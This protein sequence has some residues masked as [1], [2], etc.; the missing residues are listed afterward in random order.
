[1]RIAV[2]ADTHVALTRTEEITWHNPLR[3]ADAHVRLAAALR[4]EFVTTSNVV[5]VLG[6]LSHFGDRTSIEHVVRAFATCGR[7]VLMIGGNHDI[8]EPGV[9]LTPILQEV[10]ADS[11][12][13]TYSN[14]NGPAAK[15]FAEAGLGLQC[16]EVTGYNAEGR[17]RPMRTSCM[18]LVPPQPGG[19]TVTLAHFPV[20]S[21]RDRC[22]AAGLRYSQHRDELA[23]I[24]DAPPP[25]DP[26][27][28]LHGHLHLRGWQPAGA[29]LQLGFAALVETP[30]EVAAV[31]IE[32]GSSVR[33]DVQCEAVV[34]SDEPVPALDPPHGSWLLDGRRWRDGDGTP[35]D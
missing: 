18:E 8:W 35:E 27:L 10:A 3:L 11:V 30:F 21:L 33:V 1:V 32:L 13:G 23:D 34:D 15:A 7:P 19:L 16:W 24:D 31:D 29:V 2:I 6:D 14:Q 17:A 5:A 20:L 9:R 25:P 12:T 4:H 28:L 26:E 22:A